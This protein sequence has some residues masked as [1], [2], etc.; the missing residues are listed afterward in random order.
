MIMEV[1]VDI[2]AM[3]QEAQRN[4][5]ALTFAPLLA[6]MSDA[7][8]VRLYDSTADRYD[9][10]LLPDVETLFR[11]A[12]SALWAQTLRDEMSRRGGR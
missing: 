12:L 6:V 5:S 1:V 7:E 9:D 4:I 11:A 3:G 8:V 2:E 10:N